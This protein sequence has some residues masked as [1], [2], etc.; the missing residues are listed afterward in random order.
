[1]SNICRVLYSF[2]LDFFLN[3]NLLNKIKNVYGY[4]DLNDIKFEIHKTDAKEEGIK[5]CLMRLSYNFMV[6]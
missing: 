6:K 2:F 4:I 1:M 5:W 3:R